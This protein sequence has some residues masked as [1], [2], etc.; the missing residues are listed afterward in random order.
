MY[1]FPDLGP[2]VLDSR[3]LNQ[4]PCAHHRRP[5]YGLIFLFKYRSGEAPSAPVETDANA[6][7]V[8]FASQVI[9]NACATQAILS[10]LMNCPSTVT[11]GEELGNMKTFT[12][13]FDADLKGWGADW[14]FLT[15]C[16]RAMR[17]D[18][19]KKSA[20]EPHPRH[21]LRGGCAVVD[22]VSCI[23]PT[24]ADKSGVR[25]INV[26]QGREG[27]RDTWARIRRREAVDEWDHLQFEVVA[28]DTTGAPASQAA[29]PAAR[30][31]RI[32]GT[33][34]YELSTSHAKRAPSPEG[35]QDSATT[36]KRKV[37]A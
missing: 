4:P 11:L 7:G 12:E 35:S 1:F 19:A 8:F 34:A 27:R 32:A 3:P 29:K 23:N 21:A 17:G 15:V 6:S 31:V 10:I 14:W 30:P 22:A 18:A 25:E 2:A 24:D 13:D 5:V 9:T 37:S 20:T 36:P 26:L 28:L 16:A 33:R